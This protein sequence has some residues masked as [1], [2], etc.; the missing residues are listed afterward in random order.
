MRPRT[1]PAPLEAGAS[2]REATPPA[3]PWPHPNE[4]DRRRI[5]K[6][7]RERERYRYVS[8][9]VAPAEHG[10]LIK[11]PC[12][13][14]TVDPVGGEID[15]ARIEFQENGCWLLYRKDDPSRHWRAHSEYTQLTTLLERLVADPMRDFWR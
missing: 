9:R 4:V 7:L 15:I 2:M 3:L 11:S 6:M 12:C 1:R 10:Y 8:P 13:S 14:R 5:E